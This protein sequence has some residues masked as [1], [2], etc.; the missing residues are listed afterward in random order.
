MSIKELLVTFVTSEDASIARRSAVNMGAMLAI[1]AAVAVLVTGFSATP[2]WAEFCPGVCASFGYY[3]CGD[4]YDVQSPYC[5]GGPCVL[6][7]RTCL[8]DGC[9]ECR[10]VEQRVTCSGGYEGC[11]CP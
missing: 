8:R 11:D 4:W 3:Y 6:Q 1:V 9:P 5:G 2:A 10:C 7:Y